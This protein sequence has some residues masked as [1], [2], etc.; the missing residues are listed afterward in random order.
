MRKLLSVLCTVLSLSLFG[1][2]NT[3]FGVEMVK[4][5]IGQ[6]SAFET[7][8]KTHMARFH[9]GD[10]KRVTYEIL[11]GPRTGSYLLVDGPS[12]FADMDKERADMAVHDK[13]YETTCA[14]KVEMDGGNMI[15]RWVDTLSY[16]GDVQAD[17]YIVTVTHVKNGK[18][19]DY[20]TEMRKVNLLAMKMNPNVSFNRYVQMWS[21]SDPIMVTVSN[22]K[23][24]FKELEQGYNGMKPDDFKNAFIAEYGQGE[25]DQYQ[26]ATVDEIVSR[27]VYIMKLRKDLSSKK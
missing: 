24:G 9:N 19:A 15:Y 20:M 3:L 26:K 17:K 4:P 27:E 16:K 8:W 6:A 11:S 22:L 21:G 7:A 2:G 5:K 13:D 12:S 25:W 23:D 1:Q 14:S 10:N 18:M